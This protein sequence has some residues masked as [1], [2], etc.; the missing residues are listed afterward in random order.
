MQTTNKTMRTL[1]YA[2]LEA[3]GAANGQGNRARTQ[4][5]KRDKARCPRRQRKNRDWARGE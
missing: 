4:Q 3:A 1:S 5:S 2:N